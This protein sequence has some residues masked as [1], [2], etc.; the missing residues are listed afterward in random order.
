MKVSANNPITS[1][2]QIE[3]KASSGV[4]SLVSWVLISVSVASM[5]L[6]VHDPKHAAPPGATHYGIEWALLVSG[7]I[8]GQRVGIGGRRLLQ[9]EVD[10]QRQANNIR[11]G[12]ESPVA[13]ITAMVAI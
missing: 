1:T 13:A 11:P 8:I 7:S 10:E 5:T 9:R 6:L 4:S 12:H 3:A 2:V